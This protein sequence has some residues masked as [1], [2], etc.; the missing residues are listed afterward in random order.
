MTRRTLQILF[1]GFDQPGKDFL[2]EAQALQKSEIFREDS[3]T[4]RAVGVAPH[5]DRLDEASLVR[6]ARRLTILRTKA[7]GA[8]PR[9]SRT[10]IDIGGSRL[11]TNGKFRRVRAPL[12]GFD[13]QSPE[14]RASGLGPRACPGGRGGPLRIP[15]GSSVDPPVN[16]HRW[17]WGACAR[18]TAREPWVGCPETRGSIHCRHRCGGGAGLP[19]QAQPA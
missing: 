4:V 11:R 1:G 6:A 14:T 13:R 12:T 9:L 7:A 19:P 5:A 8:G 10:A 2:S 17:H 16:G 18:W 3:L 15:S